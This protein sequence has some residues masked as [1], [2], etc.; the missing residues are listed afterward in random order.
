MEDGRAA[1]AALEAADYDMLITDCH[2]PEIDGAALAGMVRAAETAR[3]GRRMPILGLT[4]DVTMSI[5][6]RCLAAGMNEVAVK[7]I[8]LPHLRAAIARLM[9]CGCVDTETIGGDA[10]A[11]VFDPATWRELFADDEADGR[12]WLAAYLAAA[13]ELLA[14]V[15]RHAVGGDRQALAANIHKL[16]SASLA[17]GAMR[18]GMLSRQLEAAAPRASE[19]ELH[20]LTEDVATA[21]RDAQAAIRQCLPTL[22]PVE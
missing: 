3:G 1:I 11:V 5:H 10:D 14:A 7:P 2:M 8:D 17:V 22:E 6:E 15:K 12:A 21:S 19:P 16:A 18:L 20:R 9:Q 4:A 13:T